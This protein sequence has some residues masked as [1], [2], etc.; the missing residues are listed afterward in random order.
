[1]AQCSGSVRHVTPAI[2]KTYC[3]CYVANAQSSS[4]QTILESMDAPPP[5]TLHLNAH[6]AVSRPVDGA[7]GPQRQRIER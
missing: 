3:L 7:E 5:T 2:E 6:T 1:M 4:V